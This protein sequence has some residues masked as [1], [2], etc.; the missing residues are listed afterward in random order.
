MLTF[1]AWQGASVTMI[2][3]SSTVAIS[4]TL[5]LALAFTVKSPRSLL[6]N[7]IS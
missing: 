3:T 4:V 6:K 1:G 7:A 5:F 2:V